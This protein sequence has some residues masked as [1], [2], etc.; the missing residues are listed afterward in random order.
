M[1]GSSGAAAA[2]GDGADGAAGAEVG[3]GPVGADS[4]GGVAVGAAAVTIFFG[5]AAASAAGCG[6]GVEAGVG[7][8]S[9]G[10][11]AGRLLV[12]AATT[13]TSF[14]REGGSTEPAVAASTQRGKAAGRSEARVAG[15][16]GLGFGLAAGGLAAAVSTAGDLAGAGA[17]AG[18]VIGCD[19]GSGSTRSGSSQPASA[20]TAA[21]NR[22]P[23][24]ARGRRRRR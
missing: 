22:S 4:G 14:T 12:S 11:L 18:A 17:D 1:T 3:A 24:A 2:F 9:S 13:F 6:G 15:V 23:D 20:M 19:G 10:G 7:G 21:E 8:G 5:S 16:D